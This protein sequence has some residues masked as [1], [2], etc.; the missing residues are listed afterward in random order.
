VSVLPNGAIRVVWAANDGPDGQANIYLAFAIT[1]D[2]VLAIDNVSAAEGDGGTSP[3]TFTVSLVPASPFATV[4][5]TT[6]DA[7]A[8]AGGDY[9]ATSG[10]LTFAPGETSKT[11]TVDVNGD[12]DV[13]GDETFTVVLSNPSNA[14][15]S[16]NQGI[17]TGTIQN[18][19]AG[20]TTPPE[21]QSIVRRDPSPTSL[22]SVSW[23]VTFSEPVAGA[24]AT[25][26]LLTPSGVSS[27]SISDV[28]GSS[29]VYTVTANT[30]VGS[31]TLGLNL[32]DD[33]SIADV[34]GNPLGGNGSGNGD[35]TG[36][37]YT[38]DRI[39]PAY[40]VCL[41]YD[42]LVARRA[43][44][45]YPI[46]LQLCDASGSN[47]SSASIPVHAVGVT[48]TGNSAPGPLDDTGNANPDFD[49]RYDST[50]QGYVFN[51]SL[52]CRAGLC[53]STGTYTLS[54]TAGSDPTLLSAGFAVK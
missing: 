32:A 6:A 53:F 44:T 3:F 9:V 54:F 51:L 8:V 14:I 50:I 43:G 41:L 30:G 10:T 31:G 13:E 37:E 4:D 25:D 21:V 46:R 40:N 49:F 24:D 17:A 23:T 45:A 35:F 48:Q 11:I 1:P 42:P 5:Y 27:A 26:F 20:D 36:Q 28:T 16:V 38:I 47:L 12:T 7:D 22:N 18:D 52:K 33:D 2:S 39:A 34:A 19:D 29:A 15:V